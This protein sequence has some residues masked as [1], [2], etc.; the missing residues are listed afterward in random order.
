[1]AGIEVT[2]PV[3]T[4]PDRAQS[5]LEENSGW[6]LDQLEFVERLGSIRVQER[7]KE[8]A[9]ILLRGQEVRIEWLEEATTRKYGIADFT[10]QVLRLRLP[11][12][13][14]VNRQRTVENW[15]RRE[16]K[17]DIFQRITARKTDMKVEPGNI[18]IMGQ[19]TK[20]GGCSHRRNLSFNWRLVMAPPP[21]MDYI[22]VHELAHLIEPYHSAKFWLVVRSYCPD[23]E[24]YRGWLK[25]NEW[26]MR[27]PDLKSMM[28]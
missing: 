19:R 4:A 8:A 16:A 24:Q 7:R 18:Y 13:K 1:M 17:K 5:F 9:Y 10:G 21:V 3:R 11:L 25:S 12:G 6:V 15:L 28:E 26:R 27:V 2:I 20:W 14:E 23:F 22:V